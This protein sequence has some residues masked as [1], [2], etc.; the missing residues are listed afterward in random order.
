MMDYRSHIE[1]GSLLNTPPVFAIYV[2]ALTL[3]WLKN[4]GGIAAAEKLNSQKATLLYE[5]IDALPIFE[6][7]VAKED[8]SMMNACFVATNEAL[9]KEFLALCE[10][11]GM[12]GVKGYRTVGGFRISMYNALPL[13]SV[14]AITDL[15]K[16]FAQRKG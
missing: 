16:D 4:L 14:Q 9:E 7:T 8:R 13:E 3:R 10:K 1:A 11:E 6:G 12:I 2:C 5:T 15:M